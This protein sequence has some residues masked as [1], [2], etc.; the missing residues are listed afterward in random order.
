[1]LDH[2]QTGKIPV[3]EFVNQLF[4]MQTHEHKTTHVFVKHYVEDIRKHVKIMAKLSEEWSRQNLAD[5]AKDLPEDLAK[6]P[7]MEPKHSTP[8]WVSIA[9]QSSADAQNSPHIVTAL[10]ALELP[11]VKSCN[12]DEWDGRL[13]QI[14][15]PSVSVPCITHQSSIC[16]SDSDLEIG[17]FSGIDTAI[18]EYQKGAFPVLS[19]APIV[20]FGQYL[21]MNQSNT[22]QH[23]QESS[24]G[25]CLPTLLGKDRQVVRSSTDQISPHKT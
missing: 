9:S 19:N 5:L 6:E 24:P 20:N 25:I 2:E 14:V 15:E 16:S 7:E 12:P 8:P 17:Q 22:E 4:R 11:S 10:P 3:N 13:E 18:A 21:S 23:S 1:M